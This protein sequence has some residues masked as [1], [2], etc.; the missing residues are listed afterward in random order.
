MTGGLSLT[1]EFGLFEG[2]WG[3]SE[4]LEQGCGGEAVLRKPLPGG[5]ERC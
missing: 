3:A 4:G 1:P 5:W 2:H